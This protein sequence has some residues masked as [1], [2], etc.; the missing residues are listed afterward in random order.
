MTNTVSA[1][2]VTAI[3]ARPQPR[4]GRQGTAD[5]FRSTLDRMPVAEAVPEERAGNTVTF[6]TSA[7]GFSRPLTALD[8]QVLR[9]A[10]TGE[11]AVQE[12]ATDLPNL[13]MDRSGS[14]KSPA[15]GLPRSIADATAPIRASMVM[16]VPRAPEELPIDEAMVTDDLRDA[17]TS[18][19]AVDDGAPETGGTDQPEEATGDA[20]SAIAQLA[21]VL[22]MP[23]REIVRPTARSAGERAVM[24]DEHAADDAL[25]ADETGASGLG[26]ARTDGSDT[27]Q[28]AQSGATPRAAGDKSR[29]AVAQT[30]AP[31][32]S[33]SETLA[34]PPQAGPGESVSTPAAVASSPILGAADVAPVAIRVEPS[35]R[36]A[37]AI[38]KADTLTVSA[39][40][41]NETRPMPSAGQMAQATED[42]TAVVAPAVDQ[43]SAQ[44]APQGSDPAIVQAGSMSQSVSAARSE[45]V[46][47]T[48]TGSADTKAEKAILQTSTSSYPAGADIPASQ[49]PERAAS[50]DGDLGDMPRQSRASVDDDPEVKASVDAGSRDSARTVSASPAPAIGGVPA[51]ASQATLATPAAAVLEAIRSQPTW[52]AHLNGSGSG[53]PGEVR[54]LKINLTP[55]ELGSVTAHLTIEDE[56]VSVELT[57]ETSEAQSRLTADTDT[58]VK[59]LR[60]IG[61]EV[62]RVTVQLAARTDAPAQGDTGA[63][64]RQQGFAADSGAGDARSQSSGSQQGRNAYAG[65]DSAVRTDTSATPNRTTTSRYI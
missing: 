59:S 22:M 4:G 51:S 1:R 45:P 42:R 5:A 39:F 13:E 50:S 60:A 62:D 27:K 65:E 64:A 54:S 56:S 52:T 20:V 28:D 16:D 32:A 61:L 49:V 34:Q 10:V 7:E 3:D 55:V 18:A 8:Q 41:Q 30:P 38:G 23:V 6:P 19:E 40:R 11:A 47:S 9:L 33:R 53:T 48:R 2:T 17:A 46:K 31:L 58:I 21:E 57:A 24:P 36:D 37:E 35:A 25:G 12:P 63:G 43:R 26:S 29:P 15:L 14:A 44:P